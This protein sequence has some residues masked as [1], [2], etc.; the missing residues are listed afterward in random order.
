MLVPDN[1]WVGVLRSAPACIKW[2]PLAAALA[3]QHVKLSDGW[4]TGWIMDKRGYD[5]IMPAANGHSLWVPYGCWFYMTPNASYYSN[6][7]VHVGRS[8]RV[9]KRCDVHQVFGIP[10]RTSH[11]RENPGDKLWC[12][13]ARQR[14]FDSIQVRLS[15]YA[16]AHG[17]KHGFSELVLCTGACATRTFNESACVPAARALVGSGEARKCKCPADSTVLACG[18]HAPR[19]PSSGERLRARKCATAFKFLDDV[20]D[21]ARETFRWER[22][23]NGTSE[24]VWL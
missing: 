21:D 17:K 18:K 10:Q 16:G 8:L 14:G 20:P 12:H 11:C 9:E 24:M 3:K 19:S 15:T 22:R 6:A 2:A 4:S 23:S 7:W 13:F 1:S 5:S